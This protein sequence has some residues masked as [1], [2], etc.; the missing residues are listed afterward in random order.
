MLSLIPITE[1]A[2][3]FPKRAGKPLEL[4]SI[5]R[6]ILRGCRGVKLRA[7]RD[8]HQWFTTTDWVEEFQRALTIKCAPMAPLDGFDQSEFERAKQSLQRRYASRGKKGTGKKPEVS[9]LRGTV[10]PSGTVQ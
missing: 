2:K 6:R 10:K 8:G 4:R 5:R 3:L 9:D 7:I 1:A